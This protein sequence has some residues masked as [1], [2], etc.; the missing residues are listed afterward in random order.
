MAEKVPAEHQN[1][2][3]VQEFLWNY[4]QVAAALWCED[5]LQST[6][7]AKNA[8]ETVKD[9]I[10]NSDSSNLKWIDDEF[11]ERFESD[12]FDRQTIESQIAQQK[13]SIAYE[14]FHNNFQELF[15]DK[16]SEIFGSMWDSDNFSIWEN[17][18]ISATMNIDRTNF[19]TQPW[20]QLKKFD[21][22]I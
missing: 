16:F 15:G 20:S 8:N 11:V 7:Y 21:K 2:P 17:W 9:R 6:E 1:D 13:T 19:Q 22:S 3:E 12:E 10:E 5:T 18:E 4:N 14:S